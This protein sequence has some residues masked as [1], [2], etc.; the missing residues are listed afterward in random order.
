MTQ[1]WYALERNRNARDT[2]NR[3]AG[4]CTVSPYKHSI[5]TVRLRVDISC[6]DASTG[7]HEE[8]SSSPVLTGGWDISEQLTLNDVDRVCHAREEGVPVKY[9]MH[10]QYVSNRDVDR[11]CHAR[12]E[13]VPDRL[14]NDCQTCTAARARWR[15]RAV[16]RTPEAPADSVFEAT[17]Q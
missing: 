2:L 1:H 12:E 11:V 6:I 4:K 13:G 7:W 8:G 14:R 9:G 5:C 17:P 3:T 15:G 10:I 16:P